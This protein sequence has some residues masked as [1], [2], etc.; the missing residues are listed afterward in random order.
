MCHTRTRTHTHTH[1]R[2]HTRTHTRT[3]R[4]EAPRRDARAWAKPRLRSKRN[5]TAGAVWRSPYRRCADPT[6]GLPRERTLARRAGADCALGSGWWAEPPYPPWALHR[7]GPQEGGLRGGPGGGPEGPRETPPEAPRGV[8]EDLSR[9]G[10]GGLRTPTEV[11][12][13]ATGRMSQ[14]RRRCRWHR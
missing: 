5:C 1:T 9:E 12:W 8:P 13:E 2:I 6:D 7:R 3:H 11:G 14:G 10:G 4:C